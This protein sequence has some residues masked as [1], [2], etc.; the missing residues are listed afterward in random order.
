MSAAKK[1]T[2]AGI[3]WFEIPA[4]NLKRAQRFYGA[5]FGWKIAPLPGFTGPEAQNYLHP[6][7]GGPD[8]SPDG[9]LMKR[10]HPHATTCC[11]CCIAPMVLLLAL[12]MMNPLVIIGVA[13][14]VAAE[15][16]LL[17]PEISARFAGISAIL[18]G[19]AFFWAVVLRVRD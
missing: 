11:V 7:T 16:L 17:R 1:K 9:G 12:G 4:D 19:V 13:I 18:A 14:I 2:A 10:M 3:V 15:K 6:D 8:A 5:L